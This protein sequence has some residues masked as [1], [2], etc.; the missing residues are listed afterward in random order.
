MSF[1]REISWV[2][3]RAASIQ[4]SIS[5][6]DWFLWAFIS[7]WKIEEV[8]GSTMHKVEGEEELT[9][10]VV[11]EMEYLFVWRG[12]SAGR[13]L[14]WPERKK[15]IFHK[16]FTTR[17]NITGIIRGWSKIEWKM[18]NLVIVMWRWFIEDQRGRAIIQVR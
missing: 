14:I 17:H 3:I 5:R 11:D 9:R 10:E 2:G 6:D 1:S 8:N 15:G 12:L 13:S 18:E 4:R 16:I 7:T